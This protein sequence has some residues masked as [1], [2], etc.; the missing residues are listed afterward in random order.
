MPLASG[1]L[2]KGCKDCIGIAAV[3]CLSP[4]S[5]SPEPRAQMLGRPTPIFGAMPGGSLP[6]D[7]PGPRPED[8]GLWGVLCESQ[9][10]GRGPLGGALAQ[11]P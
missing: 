5:A 7:P 4:F 8:A 6:V 2:E 3:P 10:R 1:S 11:A 9:K